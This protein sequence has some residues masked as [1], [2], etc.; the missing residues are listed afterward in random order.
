[1]LLG[2]KGALSSATVPQDDPCSTL[3]HKSTGVHHNLTPDP[4]CH[5]PGRGQHRVNKVGE[6]GI[7]RSRKTDD[8]EIMAEVDGTLRTVHD[9]VAF[10]C[11]SVSDL[12]EEIRPVGHAPDP[13]ALGRE[14][15]SEPESVGAD[16]PVGPVGRDPHRDRRDVRN[17][18]ER[19]QGWVS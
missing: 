3:G 11:R 1:M 19:Y 14:R 17:T 10:P 9:E 12:H 16:V 18:E 7:C 5:D 13:Q 15:A 8:T 6:R 2:Q 4:G